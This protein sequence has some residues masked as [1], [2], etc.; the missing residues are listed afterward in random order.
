MG[1]KVKDS[2]FVIN[3]KP[4]FLHSG[5]IHY[6][7]LKRNLWPGFLKK[8]K[9]ANLNA[10]S[11]YVPWSWHEFKEGEF[12]FSGDTL[13]ERDLIG[14]INEV[15]EA[16]L[17][18]I[19]KPGP[20]IMAEFLDEGIPDWFLN[21]HNEVF[22]C[23]AGGS[24]MG[25]RYITSM[26]PTYLDFT[27]KWYD[28]VMPIIE[29]SQVSKGGPVGMLQVCNEVGINQWLTGKGDYS[30]TSVKYFRE[31]LKNKYAQIGQLNNSYGMSCKNFEEVLPPKE[32]IKSKKDFVRWDDWHFYHRNSYARY[33]EHLS[34]SIRNY[35]INTPLFHN[36]PG[37]VFG[38]AVEFPVCISAYSQ[39][40]SEIMLGVDHIPERVSF[41]NFHDDFII[42]Q[43][44]EALQQRKFPV[45]AAEL[46]AGT[47]E[48][49]VR[50]F[51]N[52]LKLFY[53]A[54]FANGLKGMN[55][56]MF[57]QGENP[58]G[59]GAYSHLFYWENALDVSLKEGPLYKECAYIGRWLKA[60]Q[61]TLVQSSAKAELGV[62]FYP[63]Y[64]RT[65]LL[66]PLFGG[67]KKLDASEIGLLCDPKYSREKLYFETLLK[68][69]KI[70]NVPFEMVIPD[71]ISDKEL[72]KYSNLWV[73][74]LDYM[75]KP[76][77]EKI[78][79]YIKAGGN[80]LISPVLPYLDE[81]LETCTVLMNGLG[82]EQKVAKGH[83]LPRVDIYNLKGINIE[84]SIMEL[85][86]AKN[87]KEIAKVSDT[88]K[89]CG[90]DVKC[91]SG[92][93]LI[94]GTFFSYQTS[95]HIDVIKKL[96]KGVIKENKITSS[97]PDLVT[98]L[99]EN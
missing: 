65:E 43:M 85:S 99:R 83:K 59:R 84:G 34:G 38:R 96:C 29:S 79:N 71:R 21:E 92:K 40:P 67:E 47:R 62:V 66:D 76:S 17:Y 9:E 56:Y 53:K 52:E 68:I 88:G 50:T 31:Y 58:P 22:A 12:D 15:K 87:A 54:C 13:P 8:M 94:L 75:N 10:V 45:F 98:S 80:A 33:V 91:G 60:N 63:Q 90:L 3:G 78:L 86:A 32:K 20:V 41:T 49:N 74:S 28:H 82:A 24:A 42:N 57:C 48:H 89:C 61:E 81:N 5:E 69:L 27:K 11:T 16:G 23:D 37:W 35:G 18:L 95:E 51:A 30:E 73:F 64:F 44:I 7:R 77:Q 55:Y 93:A 36:V 6:F 19:L 70:L 14:F 72:S 25:G 46:Q 26:H 97:H 1:L 2:C 39:M 4:G